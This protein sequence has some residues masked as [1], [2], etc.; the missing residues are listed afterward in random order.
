M[1]SALLILGL[2]ASLPTGARIQSVHF[3]R[4]GA[5]G[6]MVCGLNE[7]GGV[8]CWSEVPEE[9]P[10][11]KPYRVALPGPASSIDFQWDHAPCALLKPQGSTPQIWCW[12][13]AHRPVRQTLPSPPARLRYGLARSK[14]GEALLLPVLSKDGKQFQSHWKKPRP[15]G[16]WPASFFISVTADGS[17]AR[18]RGRI[19]CGD[20]N[21]TYPDRG[22]ALNKG[23]KLLGPEVTQLRYY[24]RYGPCGLARDDRLYC[25]KN[26]NAWGRKRDR[27]AHRIRLPK[28]A[29][30]LNRSACAITTD[31]ALYCF[32]SDELG[33]LKPSQDPE[34]I[35]P[36]YAFRWFSKPQKIDRFGAVRYAAI[37]N[38][39]S[40]IIE[41]D[42]PNI[43]CQRLPGG[44]PIT[45]Q[46]PD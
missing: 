26:A 24:E 29:Q 34:P 9:G 38:G 7:R 41:R 8:F 39:L 20:Y 22:F 2:I 19:T 14:R 37:R 33:W 42:T 30:L 4:C 16:T 11:P 23:T 13:G 40:C 45:L 43:V 18:S 10:S 28:V 1:P 44:Q 36:K 12:R 15:L 6:S 17:C 27:L 31:G 25:W 21:W 35:L 46:L 3:S 32:G 5:E